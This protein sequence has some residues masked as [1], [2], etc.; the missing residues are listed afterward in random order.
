LAGSFRGNAA[1]RALRFDKSAA[2]AEDGFAGLALAFAAFGAAGAEAAGVEA[3]GVVADGSARGGGI[4]AVA[5]GSAEARAIVDMPGVSGSASASANGSTA[6]GKSLGHLA[7]R[8]SPITRWRA[9]G[10][11]Q[12]APHYSHYP[13]K[14]SLVGFR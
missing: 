1:W 10:P 4:A 5:T 2:P 13:A 12:G 8:D 3:E 9:P 14:M 11:V 7:M 6:I